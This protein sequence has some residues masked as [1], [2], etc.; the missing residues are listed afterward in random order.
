[1]SDSRRPVPR[2][3][4][5]H[6]DEA[7]AADIQARFERLG[8]TVSIAAALSGVEPDAFDLVILDAAPAPAADESRPN[9]RPGLPWIILA[10]DDRAASDR[11]L[12]LAVEAA[13]GPERAPSAWSFERLLLDALPESAVLI[14]RE[15]TVLA[16]NSRFLE[17]VDR[18]TDQALG[19]SIT[20]FVPENIAEIRKERTLTALGSGVPVHFEDERDGRVWEHLVI[21]VPDAAGACDRAVIRTRDITR[22][23]R[24]EEALRENETRFRL[25]F[26]Q[27]PM[28]YQSLDE[29]GY[30]LEVNPAWLQALGYARSEVIGHWFGDFLPPEYKEHFAQNFPRFK[31]IGE[32][33]GV[34]FEM[35]RKDGTR[36]LVA[37]NGRIGRDAEGRFQQTH[38]IFQDITERRRFEDRIAAGLRE[39]ELLLR[40]VHHRVKNNLQVISSLL[41]LQA[42]K[43]R[44]P[45]ARAAFEDGRNRIRAIAL[46]HE[47]LFNEE[48][49]G[50]MN[51]RRYVNQLV[52]HLAETYGSFG[53]GV[54]TR[55]EIQE[56]RLGM[57]QA[58]PLGL[59]INE[60]VSNTYKHAFPDGGPGM[61]W[62][63]A[64]ALADGWI[65]VNIGDNG[66]GLSGDPDFRG[67]KSLGLKLIS[68]LIETQLR[69]RMNLDCT[70]GTRY[71]V[72][73]PPP[74]EEAAP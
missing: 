9:L 67:S 74:E 45:E 15:G 21:P 39:K 32:I 31:A 2:L 57:D 25:L 17:R 27:A 64:R 71:T 40:E 73:F 8:Y 54:S 41:S 12:V 59:V 29:R 16:A 62:V 50:E 66:V 38:C 46:I 11:A 65:E 10:D 24:A 3:L 42:R 70:G 49:R 4:I 30:F 56:V 33:L 37:F 5:V 6:P 58:V 43:V 34:E 68:T 44:H 13:L 48:G 63:Q 60:I 18:S 52:G 47:S 20:D 53:R 1:M 7:V 14:D 51:L 36:I 35:V 69:G 61:L 23:R 72:T 55:I 26:E 19:A 22:R 28:G